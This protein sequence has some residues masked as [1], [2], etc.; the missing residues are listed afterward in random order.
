MLRVATAPKNNTEITYSEVVV[1]VAANV[2]TGIDLCVSFNEADLFEPA[3]IP[4][5]AGKN[6]PTSSLKT[7]KEKGKYISE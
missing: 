2:P 3:I 1:R 5:T 4:V 6:R 7:T